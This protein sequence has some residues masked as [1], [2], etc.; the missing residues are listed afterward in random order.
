MHDREILV[1]GTRVLDP[2]R[3]AVFNMSKSVK[4]GDEW[5]G[6]RV[7]AIT[8]GHEEIECL[9]QYDFI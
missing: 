3:R 6:F 7:P 9:K 1:M 2:E 8:Q 4:T 5:F